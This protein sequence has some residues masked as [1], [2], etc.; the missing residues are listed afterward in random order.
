[1]KI[2]NLKAIVTFSA[3]KL[4]VLASAQSG[5]SFTFHYPFLPFLRG[6]DPYSFEDQAGNSIGGFTALLKF[7]P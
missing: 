3:A 7:T 5:F 1:M 2:F 6:F 4:L